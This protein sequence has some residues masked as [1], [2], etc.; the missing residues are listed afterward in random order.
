[1]ISISQDLGALVDYLCVLCCSF[2]DKKDNPWNG[3]VPLWKP[4]QPQSPGDS[5][6]IQGCRGA[7]VKKLSKAHNKQ[8]KSQTQ[9][10]NTT[11]NQTPAHKFNQSSYLLLSPI[12]HFT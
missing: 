3:M 10:N 6:T 11:N 8:H 12:H 1:M 9:Y 4:G 7:V 2:F 5:W